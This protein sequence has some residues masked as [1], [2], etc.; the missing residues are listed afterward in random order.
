MKEASQTQ[1]IIL[2]SFN[3]PYW[4]YIS[5]FVERCALKLSLNW[6]VQIWKITVTTKSIMS[7]DLKFR[8]IHWSARWTCSQFQGIQKLLFTDGANNDGKKTMAITTMTTLVITLILTLM[9]TKT[10]AMIIVMAVIMIMMT[11]MAFHHYHCSQQQ[12]WWWF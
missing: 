5:Q 1:I 7:H 11:I 2:P 9:T 6:V 12:G 4:V 8:E 3:T 10:K